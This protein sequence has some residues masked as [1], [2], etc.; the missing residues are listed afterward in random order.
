MKYRCRYCRATFNVE[1]IQSVMAT[2][3]ADTFI[4]AGSPSVY[5]CPRCGSLEIERVY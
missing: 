5:S 1:M 2:D 3:S 4:A